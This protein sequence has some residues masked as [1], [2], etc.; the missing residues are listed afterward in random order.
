[1]PLPEGVALKNVRRHEIDK[2][3]LERHGS[4]SLFW[5]ARPPTESTRIVT[6]G[7]IVWGSQYR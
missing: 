7:A 5:A 6:V 3:K 1:M 4:L 2:G